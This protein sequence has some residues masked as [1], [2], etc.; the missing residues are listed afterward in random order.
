M[1][2]II[3][4]AG[5]STRML[6]LTED[7][8][9]CS[10]PI[11]GKPILQNTIELF[12]KN[13]VLDI[14]IIRGWQADKIVPQN[15]TFFDN[16]DF[17]NNNILHS[18]LHARPKLENALDFHED[19]LI[20]YSDIWFTD[21]VI[22][23]LLDSNQPISLVVDTEW[24]ELYQDRADHPISEA[25]NVIMKSSGYVSKIGKNVFTKSIPNKEQGEFIGLFKLRPEG[26]KTFLTH[27]DR[28]DKQLSKTD[29]FQ[30]AKEWQKAYL[31]DIFQELV[32][33][34]VKLHCVLIQKNWMEF[35][36]VQDYLRLNQ[37]IPQDLK[38][39]LEKNDEFQR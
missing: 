19:I 21:Y 37:Q 29:S 34:G 31:T 20:T 17:W 4:A 12:H 35:D 6:P 11:N 33:N 30:N 23:K 39:K 9:K 24:L 26:I 27:F 10:L 25:E 7:R 38:Q 3:I 5:P 2:G 18:L 22:K 1:K 16:T 36:T 32:D 28:I 13:G 15:V 14:S 8:P